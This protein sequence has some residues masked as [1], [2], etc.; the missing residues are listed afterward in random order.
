ME[1]LTDILR[2]S[3]LIFLWIGSVAG[4]LVGAGVVFK[5]QKIAELNQFLSRW[6]GTD[7]LGPFLDKPRWSERFF[8]RHN[9]LVG[10]GVF[11]GASLVLY[12][13]MFGYNLRRLSAIVPRGYWW[14][15][16]AL[17]TI[18]MIGSVLAALIGL[19]VLT[20]PSL[21]RDIEKAVNRWVSTEHI[22]ISLNRMHFSVERSILRHNLLTGLLIM[23]GG[24]YIVVVLSY[25]LFHGIAR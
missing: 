11:F 4:I 9:R 7:K 17:L 13:F 14:L 16:D 12:T 24:T 1:I 2:Q 5:P 22:S 10:A 20:R 3:F 18:L 19:I 6:V 23:L 25:Y 8:Y 15:L 21:L